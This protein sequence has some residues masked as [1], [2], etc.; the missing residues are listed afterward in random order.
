[1]RCRPVGARDPAASAP[2]PRVTAHSETSQPPARSPARALVGFCAAR[3][4]VPPTARPAWRPAIRRRRQRFPKM[5]CAMTWL[6]PYSLVHSLA[7]LG[8]APL[9]FPGQN[10]LLDSVRFTPRFWGYPCA[11][12]MR[13]AGDQE[14]MFPPAQL[15]DSVPA[16]SRPTLDTARRVR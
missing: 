10:H 14:L 16:S 3:R 12:I 2:G 1:M 8:I 6:D 7:L 5:R 11:Y 13:R 9:S 15:V 4:R